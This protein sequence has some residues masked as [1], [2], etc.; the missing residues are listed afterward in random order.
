MHCLSFGEMPGRAE[1]DAAFAAACPRGTFAI[2]SGNAG[3]PQG[4]DGNYTAD[5][6][7][8]LLL[9]IKDDFSDDGNGDD[10]ASLASAVMFTLGF[11]WV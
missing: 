7:H 11:E 2:C 1:F 4:I 9:E 8:V 10:G 6:L 5:E 3:T